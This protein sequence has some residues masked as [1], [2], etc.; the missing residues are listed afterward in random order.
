MNEFTVK[1]REYK[2]L[3]FC[4][5][6][7]PFPWCSC[8]CER[9]DSDRNFSFSLSLSL[10]LPWACTENER[11]HTYELSFRWIHGIGR[12]KLFSSFSTNRSTSWFHFDVQLFMFTPYWNGSTHSQHTHTHEK[13]RRQ[14]STSTSESN[15]KPYNAHHVLLALRY[16]KRFYRR[17]YN[18]SDIGQR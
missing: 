3:P 16:I 1:F 11:K 8:V 15:E 5:V 10:S 9:T 2:V 18:D 17:F 6:F 4:Q 13:P 14:H 12:L 7:V